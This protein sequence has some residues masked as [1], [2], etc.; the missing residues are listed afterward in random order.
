MFLCEGVL[1]LQNAY[2]NLR[3]GRLATL[4]E[5]FYAWNIFSQVM[6]ELSNIPNNETFKQKK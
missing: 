5:Q 3:K 2:S 4:G 6:T 1:D